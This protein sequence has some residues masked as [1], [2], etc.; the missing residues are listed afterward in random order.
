M[1][2]DL[3][4]TVS[5]DW[6]RAMLYLSDAEVE[7]LVP[8]VL[9]NFDRL[10]YEFENDPAFLVAKGVNRDRVVTPGDWTGFGQVLHS[11]PR[12]WCDPVEWRLRNV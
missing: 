8:L 4:N 12:E 9:G 10:D 3:R 5:R 11:L 1:S 6:N 2:R 7:V